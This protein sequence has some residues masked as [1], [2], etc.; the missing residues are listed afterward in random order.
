MENDI[1]NLLLNHGTVSGRTSMPILYHT[2]K[3]VNSIQ[4]NTIQNVYCLKHSYN[5]FSMKKKN[6]YKKTGKM[7]LLK[8]IAFTSGR[9][10]K[11]TKHLKVQ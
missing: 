1:I 3:T 8:N 5:V 2:V 10:L 7:D 11:I 4:Y 6:I 9:S